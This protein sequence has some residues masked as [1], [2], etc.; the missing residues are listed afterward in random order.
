MKKIV[1]LCMAA[2]G[3]M[4][5][6]QAQVKKA[7]VK[8]NATFVKQAEDFMLT[9]SQAKAAKEYDTLY[10]HD[11]YQ[12]ENCN[13]YYSLPIFGVQK[14]EKLYTND[15]LYFPLG[16][17]WTGTGEVGATYQTKNN[18]YY[19]Y[20]GHVLN[21]Y[22]VVGA[23][24]YVFRVGNPNAWANKDLSRFDQ[25]RILDYK[26]V[27]VPALP[28]KMKGYKKVQMQDAIE[29][30]YDA[31]RDDVAEMV[32]IEMPLSMM[33]AT[34]TPIDYIGIYEPRQ[35]EDGRSWPIIQRVGGLFEKPFLARN[36]FGISI[37]AQLTGNQ[38]YDSLWNWSLIAKSNGGTGACHFVDEWASWTR[39]D[40]TGGFDSSWVYMWLN[41]GDMNVTN[42]FNLE[43]DSTGF[44]PE[45]CPQYGNGK[46]LFTYAFALGFQLGD[47]NHEMPMI[48]PIIQY[49]AANESNEAYGMTVSVYPV[50]AADKVTVT[51]LDKIQ[52]M[53]IYDMTGV[54]VRQIVVNENIYEMNVTTMVPGTYVAKIITD[55]GVA[56]K[57]LVVR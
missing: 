26:G 56:S 15:V 12:T 5:F 48:Y 30:Y 40:F 17:A 43:S 29:S 35:L 6:A 46:S 34:E 47:G 20:S 52:K 53:E 31:L 9:N 14:L 42:P 23:I 54:L 37:E 2:C 39:L 25:N 33:D 49:A 19:E 8:E 21:D 36:N 13:N 4:T 3:L 32:S 28:Y 50:P 11:E 7:Q 57:K 55:K 51:S 41:D 18:I 44:A 38:T 27:K 16:G 10:W 22:N 24:G 45:G 1:V